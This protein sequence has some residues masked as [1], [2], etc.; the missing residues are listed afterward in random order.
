MVFQSFAVFS[1][2]SLILKLFD[3]G[4]S[5]NYLALLNKFLFS[6]KVYLEVNSFSG[7]ARDIGDCGLPQGSVLS[8]ILFKFYIFDLLFNNAT[9]YQQIAS[10]VLKFADDMIVV[11]SEGD[12]RSCM[13]KFESVSRHI[14]DWCIKWRM[15]ISCDVG[16]TGYISFSTAKGD[17]YNALLNMAFGSKLI[18]KVNY[19]RVLGLCVD[20]NLTFNYNS[21]YVCSRLLYL[22][23]SILKCGNEHWAT[24]D[25]TSN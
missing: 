13:S 24:S 18:Q 17:L 25:D 4:V 14:T 20:S 21:Q 12:T 5:E 9:D 2:T 8:P 19:T 7:P 15:I 1:R 23:F 22:W 16:K 11:L 6:R 10:N 3:H